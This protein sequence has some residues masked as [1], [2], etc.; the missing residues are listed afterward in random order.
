MLFRSFLGLA[1]DVRKGYG[2]IRVR[3]RVKTTAPVAT[4]ESLASY[5]PMLE[6]ISASVPV[7]V[8]VETF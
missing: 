1:P 7:S 8:K 5:S 3:M 2:A 4:I 6:V